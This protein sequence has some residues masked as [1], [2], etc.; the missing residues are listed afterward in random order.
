MIFQK[1]L[2]KY[3]NGKGLK[4]KLLVDLRVIELN[5]ICIKGN[6]FH[7]EPRDRFSNTRKWVCDKENIIAESRTKLKSRQL[8]IDNFLHFSNARPEE[9][10]SFVYFSLSFSCIRD[11][12]LKKPLELSILFFVGHM[13]SHLWSQGSSAS[14]TFALTIYKGHCFCRNFRTTYRRLL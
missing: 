5:Q 7:V 10:D 2:V 12:Y 1:L 14:S 13:S 11:I 8:F 9:S 3:A 4:K 6:Y